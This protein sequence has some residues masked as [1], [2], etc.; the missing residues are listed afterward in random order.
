MGTKN[1][2]TI[3]YCG[4]DTNFF[5]Q[6]QER[7]A[8]AYTQIEFV[9]EQIYEEDDLNHYKIFQDLINKD[10]SIM[11]IDFSEDFESQSRLSLTLKRAF[12][13]SH[14]P[15][16]G[17][18]ASSDELHKTQAAMTDFIHVK[19]G[20]QHD[21]VYDPFVLGFPG[22]AKN[23]G[24]ANAKANI[25]INI[26]AIFRICYVAEDYMRVEGNIQLNKGDL[27]ELESSITDLHF[28]SN[29]YGVREVYTN[30]LFYDYKYAY[31]LDLVFLDPPNDDMDPDGTAEEKEASIQRYKEKIGDFDIRLKKIKKDHG[32]WLLDNQEKSKEKNPKVLVIDPIFEFM[33][34]NTKAM[35]S[36]PHLIRCQTEFTHDMAMVERLRPDIIAF[37]FFLPESEQ[38]YES[39]EVRLLEESESYYGIIKSNI[40][41]LLQ[42]ID[43]IG[44]PYKPYIIVFRAEGLNSEKLQETYNY[45]VIL[46]NTGKLKLDYISQICEM[47]L[48]KQSKEFEEV[49]NK[50]II[51]LRE[52]D[53]QKNGRLTIND[54]IEKK[55]CFSKTQDFSY[56]FAKVPVTIA[57]LSESEVVIKS[58]L[59]LEL[60]TYSA[61]APIS[62]LFRLVPISDKV[63]FEQDGET[64]IYRAMTHGINEDDKQS[65]RQVVNEIY[66]EPKREIEEKSK[67]D[68]ADINQKVAGERQVA[69]EVEKAKVMEDAAL[70][71]EEA[72]N[73]EEESSE[74]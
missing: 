65:L 31:D 55:Y 58:N 38:E 62:M 14:I 7:M 48:T 50:K 28:E 36:Y 26:T 23:P 10:I 60:S 3:V 11:Y 22:Q 30:N 67:Q 46:C 52:Q 13:F 69:E 4:K 44:K 2:K 16:V 40:S 39:E 5:S 49:T 19:C 41:K 12:A 70:E 59:E 27:I 33:K 51:K 32:I 74:E 54:F 17:L 64:F 63:V 29:N 35:D 72:P 47:Y 37:Q 61:T 43:Q 34:E 42:K 20:E 18:V 21:L 66:T 9:F 56:A 71:T 68:F 57:K 45:P 25:D 8:K 73:D 24:Y 1:K 15:L 53:Y 6:I